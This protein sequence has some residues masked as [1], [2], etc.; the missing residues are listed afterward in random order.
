MMINDF[1][2]EEYLNNNF[3]QETLYGRSQKTG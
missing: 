2:V 3:A 1:D